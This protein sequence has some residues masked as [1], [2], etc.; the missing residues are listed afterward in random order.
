MQSCTGSILCEAQCTGKHQAGPRALNEVGWMSGSVA[1]RQETGCE[2]HTANWPESC[3]HTT[4]KHSLQK[5]PTL[6]HGTV[7]VDIHDVIMIHPSGR[8]LSANNLFSG[9]AE[10]LLCTKPPFCQKSAVRTAMQDAENQADERQS[11]AY[12][13]CPQPRTGP[14][15]NVCFLT[16]A[17]SHR[18]FPWL[19]NGHEF[20]AFRMS[21]SVSEMSEVDPTSA[22]AA[23][24]R[25]LAIVDVVCGQRSH[26]PVG[27]LALVEQTIA[28]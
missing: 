11:W 28:A 22:P 4:S 26:T 21:H 16:R 18:A 23:A 17:L 2:H 9:T 5:Y 3:W 14:L 10:H 24:H 25:A 6:C 7:R 19:R 20:L 12:S 1:G 8:G 15:S 27:P 13:A